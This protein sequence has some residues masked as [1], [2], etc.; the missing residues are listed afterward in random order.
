LRGIGIHD[1]Y[2]TV[3]DSG[4]LRREFEQEASQPL[5]SEFAREKREAAAAARV[6]T[7][8]NPQ[9]ARL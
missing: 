7:A 1:Y 9:R 4:A 3:T 6:R 5:K 8:L 2:A